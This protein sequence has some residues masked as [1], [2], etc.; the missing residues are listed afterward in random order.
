MS[1][2]FKRSIRLAAGITMLAPS[3]SRRHRLN[4]QLPGKG[5]VAPPAQFSLPSAYGVWE[6]QSVFL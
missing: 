2:T 4:A 3:T 1:W 6:H 5:C